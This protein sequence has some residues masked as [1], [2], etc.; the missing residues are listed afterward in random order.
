MGNKVYI[1]QHAQ[2]LQFVHHPGPAPELYSGKGLTP[3]GGT[4]VR[5]PF[6]TMA[7]NV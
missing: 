3:S 4:A 5:A 2:K 6:I 7:R 1:A